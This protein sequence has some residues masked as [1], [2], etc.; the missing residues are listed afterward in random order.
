MNIYKNKDCFLSF[1]IAQDR[2]ELKYI[3][4]NNTLTHKEF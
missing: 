1:I 3:D 2:L 4:N